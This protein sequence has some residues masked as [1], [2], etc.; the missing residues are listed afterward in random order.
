MIIKA[1]F[2]NTSKEKIYKIN[3]IINSGITGN[4][5]LSE[6]V[7][8][9]GIDIR[10]KTIFYKLLVINR[11]TINTNRGII[12]IKTKELIIEISGEYLEYI[13]INIIF[14]E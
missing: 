3:I 12:D 1:E 10:I 7:F 11:E 4:F 8:I 2:V 14:I 13:I 9:F 6:I 5:I